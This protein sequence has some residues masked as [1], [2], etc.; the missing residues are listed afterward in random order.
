MT[1]VSVR[2][3]APVVTGFLAG[4]GAVVTFDVFDTLIWRRVLFPSD[5]FALLPHGRARAWRSAVEAWVTAA[6]RRLLRREPR[7]E[8]IYRFYRFDPAAEL[9]LEARLV[10]ANPWCLDLV[11]VLHARGVAMAAVSDMY[12]SA[13][14]ITG[15]L[16]A[17]GYPP[18]PVF[19]SSETNA[20]K[21]GEGRLFSH[22]GQRLGAEP[23]RWMHVGDNHHADV[24]MAR[25]HGLATCHLLTPRDT[26]LALLPALSS[27][28]VRSRLGGEEAVVFLGDLAIELHLR[29]AG[30]LPEAFRAP[31]GARLEAVLARGAG[32]GAPSARA[33]VEA[34]LGPADGGAAP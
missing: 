4:D 29:G 22:V 24:E 27:A 15:L 5:L 26:L 1:T 6:C 34:V 3:A 25:R 23:A 19:V 28:A 17:A 16:Q 7:L 31:L 21:H 18:L 12:L 30:E 33:V 10:R 2:D 8:D 14:Q 13:A 20:S 32:A 9:A 11:R